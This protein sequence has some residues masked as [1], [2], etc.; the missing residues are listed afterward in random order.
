MGSRTIRTDYIGEFV[1]E[2]DLLQFILQE[3]GR[4]VTSTVRRLYADAGES[5][6]T[7]TATGS[8]TLATYTANGETYVKVTSS[9][10]QGNGVLK[11]GG[12]IS[13]AAN[14]K[15]KI[16]LKGYRG[17]KPV[18]LRVKVNNADISGQWP[19]AA[20]PAG[21]VAESWVEQTV[22]VP[23]SGT[24]QA[25]AAWNT[26]VASGAVFYINEVEIIRLGEQAPEYQYHLKDHLG[27]VRLTFTSANTS[28]AITATLE[29][30]A[31]TQDRANFLRYDNAKR[32]NAYLFDRTNGSAPSTTTGYSQRLA[33]DGATIGRRNLQHDRSHFFRIE[34]GR[35]INDVGVGRKRLGLPIEQARP[36]Q[37][38]VFFAFGLTQHSLVHEIH[39]DCR[40]APDDGFYGAGLNNLLLQFRVCLYTGLSSGYGSCWFRSRAFAAKGKGENP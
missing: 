21:A 9:A 35:E 24:L 32:I 34:E 26:D 5:T 33:D 19:G 38:L 30:A 22:T 6:G 12:D 16:R 31:A 10:T 29:S 23:A 20:L 17:T 39:I 13:V 15:Y 37:H 28:E 18:Y 7:M 8:A 27:N 25:G 11:I 4:I 1:Y 40:H 14:E 2:N 36:I 3:E